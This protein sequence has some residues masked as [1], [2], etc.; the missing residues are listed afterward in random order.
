MWESL[1]HSHSS[2][3]LCVFIHPFTITVLLILAFLSPMAPAAGATEVPVLHPVTP[4][5][6]DREVT[7]PGALDFAHSPAPPF[8]DMGS[9]LE[10]HIITH[11]T[12]RRFGVGF[13]MS[14]ALASTLASFR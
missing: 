9:P 14:S 12:G 11:E 6:R 3:F 4:L 7:L 13:I 1:N 5:V 10:G 2:S 8:C